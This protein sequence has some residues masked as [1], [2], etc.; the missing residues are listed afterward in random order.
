MPEIDRLTFDI[1]KHGDR[2]DISDK[3]KITGLKTLEDM[4]ADVTAKV[5]SGKV[6][7][8][9][10]N[11]ASNGVATEA[12]RADES[13]TTHHWACET[14][15]EGLPPCTVTATGNA[16]PFPA[17]SECI[18]GLTDQCPAWKEIEPPTQLPTVPGIVL[19]DKPTEEVVGPGVW[20]KETM[21]GN[22]VEWL[23]AGGNVVARLWPSGNWQGQGMEYTKPVWPGSI[24]QGRTTAERYCADRNIGG[25]RIETNHHITMEAVGDVK[26]KSYTLYHLCEVTAGDPYFVSD[27][28]LIRG[29][30]ENQFE[31]YVAANIPCSL[32]GIL[33]SGVPVVLE[34]Y[35]PKT[36]KVKP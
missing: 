2:T 28:W 29:H 4:I 23:V 15:N 17:P 9:F 18:Y 26:F 31:A 27:D 30:A 1:E 21:S 11:C 6:T 25:Y 35:D 16:T 5:M 19:R 8:V 33:P 32:C 36:E 10:T 20:I 12:E 24:D 3:D 14:C 22:R 34:S 13:N 7:G